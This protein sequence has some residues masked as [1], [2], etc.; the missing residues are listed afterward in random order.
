MSPKFFESDGYELLRKAL[1]SSIRNFYVSTNS[2]KSPADQKSNFAPTQKDGAVSDLQETVRTGSGTSSSLVARSR[3]LVH[4]AVTCGKEGKKRKALSLMDQ[5]LECLKKEPHP[6]R[7]FS[8]CLH[9]YY[10]RLQDLNYAGKA[11]YR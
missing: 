11:G 4:K 8:R 1:K 9:F 7:Y 10:H 5:A 2:Q 6:T 3:Y